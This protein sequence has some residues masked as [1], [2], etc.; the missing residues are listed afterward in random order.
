[1]KKEFGKLYVDMYHLQCYLF[2]YLLTL[3]LLFLYAVILQFAFEALRT[4][5]CYKGS[6]DIVIPTPSELLASLIIHL[7]SI[8]KRMVRFL[9][10]VR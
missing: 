7:Y 2:L 5:I 10:K 3:N 6:L 1:M 4:L 8:L 9:K